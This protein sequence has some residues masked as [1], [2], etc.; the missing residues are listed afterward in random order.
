MRNKKVAYLYD[1]SIGLFNYDKGHPINPIRVA[2]TH[3]LVKSYNL[4]RELDLIVPNKTKLTYHSNEYFENLGN[5]E[6]EDCPNFEGIMNYVERYSSASINAAQLINSKAYDRVIN[7]A[8]GLHH[9][10]KN[11]ASGFCF[12]NDIVMCIQELLKRHERVMYIDIDVHH[13]D[14]VEE[15]FYENERVL[16][17]SIHKHGD[18]FF[19]Q[20]GELITSNKK[21]VNIPLQNGITDESYKY[22]YE[23]VIANCIKKFAPNAIVLQCGADSLA[24]DKLGVFSLSMNGHAN[25]MKFVLDF[26]IPTVIL[27]GGGYTIS[28]VSR[29]WAYETAIA[30]NKTVPEIIP[31]SDSFYNHYGPEY[32]SVPE[33]ISK[34]RINNNG[35]R[36]LDSIKGF[37]LERVDKFQ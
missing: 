35:K 9:A 29:A 18:G 19:P 20:T 8:G 22:I 24:E 5:E 21:A 28:N 13:G 27:G 1:D 25:A 36:Y 11:E 3:S 12:S 30:C 14:G 16:T 31:M 6:T 4:D 32:L 17:L 2:M 15:A 37:I 34:Y 33:L 23:P 26:D 7:W 10:K